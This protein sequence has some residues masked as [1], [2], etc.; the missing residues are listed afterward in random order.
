MLLCLI[1]LSF[2]ARVRYPQWEGLSWPV[3]MTLLGLSLVA[4]AW[5]TKATNGEW[6][7]PL[8]ML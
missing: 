4:N 2:M 3:N 8:L 1:L 6:S 5:R 7:R